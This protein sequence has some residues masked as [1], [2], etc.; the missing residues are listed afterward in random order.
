MGTRRRLVNKREHYVLEFNFRGAAYRAGF[1]FFLSGAL[2]EIFLSTGKPNSES[3]VAANDAAILCSLALQHGVPL[4]TIRHGLLRSD[5]N[6]A[7]GPLAHA[8]DLIDAS[9]Y[10]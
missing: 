2:A 9:T 7:S 5:N 4:Q 3:D 1:S 8:L 10:R 6:D